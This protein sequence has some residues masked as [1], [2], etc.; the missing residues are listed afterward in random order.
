MGG[1]NQYIFFLFSHKVKN[2]HCFLVQGIVKE[3]KSLGKKEDKLLTSKYQMNSINSYTTNSHFSLVL[4]VHFFAFLLILTCDSGVAH[5][6]VQLAEKATA[7]HSSTLAWNIPWTEEPVRLQS[8]GSLR[9][10][11]D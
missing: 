11:H 3:Q 8:M 4:N 7:P 6:L 5:D 2:G 1:R 9:V 10:G